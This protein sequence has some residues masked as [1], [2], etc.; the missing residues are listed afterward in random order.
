MRPAVLFAL[1]VLALGVLVH[2]GLMWTQGWPTVLASPHGRDFASYYYAIQAA[3]SGLDP[4]RTSALNTLAQADG[5]RSSVYPFFYPPPY[6]LSMVW[7]LPM[8]LKSAYQVWF[9]A[10][11][12]FGLAA[13]AGLGLWRR[14]AALA[15][16]GGVLLATFTPWINNHQ[17]GQANL[18]VLALM[19]FGLLMVER[20]HGALGGALMGAACMMKMSPGLIVAWWL[21]RRDWVPALSACLTA[22]VLSVAALP[23]VDAPT[24]AHF[25]FKVLPSFSTGD[26]NG[27]SVPILM[28]GNHSIPNLWAQL[29]PGGGQLSSAARL[30]SGLSNLGL[31]GL[32][33]ALLPRQG[34]DG[35]SRMCAAGALTVVMLIVPVYTYE[36]HLSL[37]A[38]PLLAL[39]AAIGERRLGWGWAVVLLLA[40]VPL[41]WELSALKAASLRQPPFQSWIL[42]EIKFVALLLVGLAC[43]V[44]ARAKGVKL[45]GGASV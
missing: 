42:Q 44:A 3:A 34:D 8:S 18:P 40:Y 30:A 4:Y 45:R 36:H 33:L 38:L 26:Y 14:S 10:D 25:Y 11:G 7:A 5:T 21:L 32:T 23:L 20:K 31:I 35:L 43:V 9:W 12:L 37:M 6:L 17:M 15:F 1:F 28:F 29:F 39:C 27:L 2:G 41:A 24:Q 13:L 19:V 16:G 22:V